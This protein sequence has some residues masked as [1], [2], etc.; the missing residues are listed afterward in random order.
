MKSLGDILRSRLRDVLQ[1]RRLAVWY[2]PGGSLAP[3]A[4]SCVPEGATFVASQ[5]S[6]L[7]LRMRVEEADPELQRAW[8]LYI[9]EAPEKPSWLRDYELLGS[10]ITLGLPEILS[11][12]FDLSLDKRLREMLRGDP[13]RALVARWDDLTSSINVLD[14]DFLG[15]ALL[16][17]A[18]GAHT[19]EARDIVLAYV[20]VPDAPERLGKLGVEGELRALLEDLGLRDLPDGRALQER[21][22]GALLLSELTLKTG[23]EPGGLQ[24]NL[25]LKAKRRVWA[26]W[27]EVWARVDMESFA[28][29]ALRLEQQYALKDKVSGHHLKDVLSFPCVDELLLEEVE[30]LLSQGLSPDV[31]RTVREIA[32]KRQNTPWASRRAAEGRPLPW[33]G[34]LAGL[35]VFERSQAAL[36]ALRERR[37]LRLPHLLDEYGK[38]DGWWR[39]DDAFR[40]LDARRSTWSRALD[41]LLGR[42][43]RKVF[44]DFQEASGRVLAAHLRSGAPWQAEGWLDQGEAWRALLGTEDNPAVILADALRFDLAW[45]LAV[46]LE[47]EG[48]KVERRPVLARLPSVTEIGMACLVPADVQRE[49]R[50]ERGRLSVY[51]GTVPLRTRD[52]RLAHLR[53]LFPRARAVDLAQ[54]QRGDIPKPDGPLIVLAQDV[55]EQGAFLPETGLDH[56]LELVR[57]L[58]SA[59]VRLLEA[60]YPRVAVFA[61]HGFLLL[62]DPPQI[63][64]LPALPPDDSTAR[65]RRY[66]LGKPPEVEGTVR[67]PVARL[68]FAGGL[69]AIFPDGLSVLGVQGPVPRFL[70]GGPLPCETALLYLVCKPGEGMGKPLRVVIVKPERIDTLRPRVRLEGAPPE[71]LWARSRTVRVEALLGDDLLARSD[72]VTLAEPGDQKEVSLSLPRYGPQV[73]LRVVDVRTN[74]VV[75]RRTV[76][77]TL[78]GGYDEAA[79]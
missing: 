57:V 30:G 31:V 34:I 53:K 12:E 67:V 19:A 48:V 69:T 8:V 44:L 36:A 62:P 28:R 78:P 11:R 61:D 47:R 10:A 49:V 2:D 16:A 76:P 39:I 77:V 17:A 75:A 24:D 15:R 70:H 46:A 9:P 73:E 55:D 13:G 59:V 37:D 40:R 60:G 43:A 32:E 3:L 79:P 33:E 4:E 54:V 71:T 14:A 63:P 51:V 26:P 27:A 45:D 42:A 21:V 7:E 58:Q 66:A 72:P 25:P 5:G 22:A 35:D 20:S 64:V 41:D 18:L 50:V 29:W 74:E 6:L 68:G 56:F 65:A 52:E 38:E 23:S 1:K